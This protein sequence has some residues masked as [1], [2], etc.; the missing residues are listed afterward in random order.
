MKHENQVVSLEL[1]K[2]LKRA[3][4]KQEVLFLKEEG[5]DIS[6]IFIGQEVLDP[7]HKKG[8][9]KDLKMS[10][11]GLNRIYAIVEFEKIIREIP[12]DMLLVV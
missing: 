7:M 2:Q 8:I 11:S 10:S 1:S 4:Y 3:G 9:V 12:I 5:M 6:R